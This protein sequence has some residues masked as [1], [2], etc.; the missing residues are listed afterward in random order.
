M[1]NQ[2]GN[3]TTQNK[4]P[5]SQ[6]KKKKEKQPLPPDAMGHCGEVYHP[7]LTRSACH[8]NEQQKQ[9]HTFLVSHTHGFE[10]I[11]KDEI[12][13]LFDS[14]L[15]FNWYEKLNPKIRVHDYPTTIAGKFMKKVENSVPNEL[16]TLSE[17]HKVTF[18]NFSNLF[19][20]EFLYSRNGLL[21]FNVSSKGSDNNLFMENLVY[22]VCHLNAIPSIDFVYSFIC[23][24]PDIPFDKETA[25][26]IFAETIPKREQDTQAWKQSFELFEKLYCKKFEKQNLYSKDTN[27]RA[28]GVRKQTSI[29]KHDYKSMDMAAEYGY[30]IG[31]TICKDMKVNLKKYDLDILIYLDIDRVFI[32]MLLSPPLHAL[33]ELKIRHFSLN[34]QV[35]DSNLSEDELNVLNSCDLIY[36]YTKQDIR[37]TYGKSTLKPQTSYMLWKTL[38][39]ENSILRDKLFQ[40]SQLV[41]FVDPFAGSGTLSLSLNYLFTDNDPKVQLYNI[42]FNLDEVSAMKDNCSKNRNIHIL[43]C[44]SRFLPFRNESI[45]VVIS[46]MPFGV[47]CGNHSRNSKVYP[48]IVKQLERIVKPDGVVLLLTIELALLES[49][50]N[51]RNRWTFTTQKVTLGDLGKGIQAT[52]YICKKKPATVN[53]FVNL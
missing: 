37:L 50:L 34:N 15:Q 38:L 32:G 48:K 13:S 24:V 49:Q 28:T 33:E 16:K 40:Q 47:L 20:I 39:M 29:L 35:I 10:Q 44:D 19:E 7:I 8:S 41:T 17:S 9:E 23:I 26:P 18:I 21:I 14:N 4:F 52:I 25:M 22:L 2:E 46:D 51:A 36:S 31:E 5:S 45:D 3:N 43:N 53:K 42:D 1:V 30:G 27:F 6:K 11:V 12:L